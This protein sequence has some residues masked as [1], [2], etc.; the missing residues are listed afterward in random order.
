MII[1]IHC[2]ADSKTIQIFVLANQKRVIFEFNVRSVS[3]YFRQFRV[4]F[5]LFY[6][7]KLQNG[8]N[9]SKTSYQY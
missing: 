5:N 3:K 8:V 9:C 4:I 2:K 7:A 1:L 6:C